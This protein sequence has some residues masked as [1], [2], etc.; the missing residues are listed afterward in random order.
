MNKDERK[1]MV[2]ILPTL[3]LGKDGMT[4][5]VVKE[6]MY[7]LKKRKIVKVKVL[8]SARSDVPTEEIGKELAKLTGARLIGVRGGAILL[9]RG[10]KKGQ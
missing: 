6:V 3:H 9:E 5:G 7:Q 1:K 8:K 4:D 2:D 10:L